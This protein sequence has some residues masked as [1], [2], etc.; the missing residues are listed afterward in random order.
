MNGS[1][2]RMS[3]KPNRLGLMRKEKFAPQ[4]KESLLPRE[5]FAEKEQKSMLMEADVGLLARL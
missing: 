3:P 1:P 4:R 5:E 2:S